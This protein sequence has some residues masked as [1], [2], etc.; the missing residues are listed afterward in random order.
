[1]VEAAALARHELGAGWVDVPMV[2]NAER[3]DP[4]GTDDDSAVVRAAR[5][6]R[7]LTA[8]DEGR[9][10]R[11]RRDGA[12]AVLRLEAFADPDEVAHRAAWR[13]HGLGAL[14]A[15]WRE[16]WRERDRDPGWIEAHWHDDPP[17]PPAGDLAPL[18]LDALADAVDWAVVEDHTDAA[19]RDVVACYQ[20]LTV[21]A[22]RG[23]AIVVVRHDLGTDVDEPARR[24]ALSA[25]GALGALG[26]LDGR[27]D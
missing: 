6:A 17:T 9:A 27:S 12:L 8:L 3:A 26:P 24:L 22:G 10:W 16:R 1:V 14:D 25:L 5:D 21:W 15:T 19:R 23:H 11:R 4:F 20:H 2:N 18:G 7:R 13:D